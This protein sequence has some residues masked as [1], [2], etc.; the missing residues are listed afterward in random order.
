MHFFKGLGALLLLLCGVFVGAAAAALER[1]RVAQAEGFLRLLG[2]IRV[3]I[4]CFSLPLPRIFAS[5]DQALW[6]DLGAT[7]Q[8]QSFSALLEGIR[9]YLA[10]DICL[11]L[12]EFGARL[13]NG[14]REEELRALD[15]YMARLAPYCERLR[16][17]LPQRLRLSWL[18]PLALAAALVLLLL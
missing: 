13:G 8:P 5:C 14:Y 12:A 7:L 9:L 4:E 16:A 1:R 11:L 2:A 18:L 17:E 10:P 3:Q 15:Y 6:R